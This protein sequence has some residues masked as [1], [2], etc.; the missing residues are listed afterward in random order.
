[1][2]DISK[3][4][5]IADDLLKNSNFIQAYDTYFL[6]YSEIWCALAKFKNETDLDY[7]NSDDEL[8][9]LV[10]QSKYNK[11][12]FDIFKIEAAEV[13]EIFLHTIYGRLRCLHSSKSLNDNSSL[14][15]IYNEILLLYILLENK[16]EVKS[17]ENIFKC[18]SPYV[19]RS[20]LHT[21]EMLKS[22]AT[23]KNEIL[24]YASSGRWPLIRLV[25]MEFMYNAK[26]HNSKFFSDLA[27][28]KK[29]TKSSVRKLN[30]TD[31]KNFLEELKTSRK[32]FDSLAASEN[33]K[34]V[35]YG[36]LLGLEGKVKKSEIRA[37]YHKKVSIYHPDKLRNPSEDT[38]KRIEE[39]T[40]EIN[41]AFEWFKKKYKL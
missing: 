6:I 39:K 24:K 2:K 29:S 22:P 9:E 40:K 35:Y 36:K 31:H 28:L 41:Q 32:K 38:L 20:Q 25:L 23:I 16:D 34:A 5:H 18:F 37:F 30:I 33:E 1:M 3:F 7:K 8:R 11:F 13:L 21:I 15:L 27:L 26:V 10:K 14:T 12:F 19:V 17:L 4:R